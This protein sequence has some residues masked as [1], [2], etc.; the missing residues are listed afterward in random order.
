MRIHKLSHVIAVPFALMVCYVLY[1]SFLNKNSDFLIY[2][3]IPVA[4]LILI[5]LFQPQINY[6]WI[7]RHPLDLDEKIITMLNN[8]NP[9]Y[10]KMNAEEKQDFNNR[11][12]LYA[13]GNAFIA[14]GMEQDF[15]VPYDVK[16]MTG[17]IPVTMM[18]NKSDRYLV[19][20]ER[21][22]I[23]KHP[24]PSPK[25]KFLHT[26]E[27]DIEDGVIIFSLENMEQAFFNPKEYFNVAWWAYADAYVKAYPNQKY[28]D[29][30]NQIWHSIEAIS[31]F[32][33]ERLQNILGFQGLDPLPI[34]IVCYFLNADIFAAK[35]PIVYT[36]IK[37]IFS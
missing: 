25:Y 31:G 13:E 12:G 30:D 32:T 6:W 15:E 5:Y 37:D 1:E 9:T 28:P 36:Q 24:F 18:W 10:V 23:Y 35:A 27:T 19:K 11:L 14:K 2:G 7:S 26:A 22:I 20:F 16:M 4:I 33:Q 34:L 3:M 17:Q 21:V 8:T 29:V